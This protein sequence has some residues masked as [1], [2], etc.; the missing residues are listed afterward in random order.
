MGR[1]DE[2][3]P[4]TGRSADGGSSRPGWAEL[5]IRRLATH[6]P[7]GSA[8]RAAFAALAAQHH[9]VT[10]RDLIVREGEP[11]PRCCLLV[12]GF[13]GRHKLLADG[14]RQV[15][16]LHVAGDFL[17]LPAL[18]LDAPDA[19]VSSFGP[20]RVASVAR[21]DL[22]DIAESYPEIA[23]ALWRETL[24]D[25]ANAREW[26]LNIGQR[27]AYARLAHLFCEMALRLEAVGLFDG[28]AF[29]FPVPQQGLADA[30]GLS[31]VHVN[32]VLQRLR[33]DGLLHLRGN[34][35][36]I[37][38]RRALAAAGGFDPAYLHLD[39]RR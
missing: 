32:R 2:D 30:T 34:H 21:D 20:A 29:A 5:A 22:A 35:A 37:P 17:D 11:T 39:R 3:A 25:A 28:G 12:E 14:S 10:A 7:L 18:L 31:P 8:E 38:D 6:S 19:S 9:D 13:A 16:S 33:A 4:L 27:D 1:R 23:R 26:L 15:V 24:I 36:E